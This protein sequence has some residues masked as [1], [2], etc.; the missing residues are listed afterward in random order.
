MTATKQKASGKIMPVIYVTRDIERA[1]GVMPGL[2]TLDGKTIEYFVVANKTTYSAEICAQYPDHVFL[3]EDAPAETTNK[4]TA[5]SLLDTY[6]LLTNDAAQKFI[7][8][9]IGTGGIVVFHN[10]SRI[11]KLCAEKKWRLL[12]PSAALAEKIE[13][14][15]TQ[16][17]WLEELADLLPTHEVVNAGDIV[18]GQTLSQ[19]T[20]GKTEPFI[21]QWA[22]SH[23]GDGTALVRNAKDLAIIK[24]K[25]PAREARVSA[26]IKGPMFT[27]NICVAP[28][29]AILIGNI[30]YQ[31]TGVLPFTDNPFSTIGNDWSV[32]H[33]ILSP[34]KITQFND[35]AHAVGKKMSA[36]GWVGLF[37]IDCIYDEER[38]TVHLIEINARQPASTTYE[39]Q[40]Q[41]TF[42]DQIQFQIFQNNLT[43]FEGHLASLLGH[44]VDQESLTLL[45]I[46]DGAQIIQRL[47]ESS[48]VLMEAPEKIIFAVEA[49]STE[50]FTVIEYANT[51][52]NSDLLRIQ[53][54]R[55]IME[56][57]LKFNTRGKKI[58]DILLA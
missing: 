55:G 16:V 39:S 26:F 42:R 47:T 56:A 12:N 34:E 40:L 28:S 27:A 31:I 4:K 30:S 7:S 11:E 54:L 33:S 3:V 14:K 19:K 32:P 20:A 46:N 9:K 13:N 53:S 44:K 22:H 2:V 50:G 21:I 24:E 1:L 51:K 15:I 6:D 29:S 49:L 17:E 8:K 43:T 25:F 23:T 57:H 41:Q 45:E 18:W 5:N 35:I 48:T 10:T 58:V 52:A 36:G 37:G 38:D